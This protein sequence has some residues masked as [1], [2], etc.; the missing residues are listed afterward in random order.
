MKSRQA[1]IWLLILLAGSLLL[2]QAATRHPQIRRQ[3]QKSGQSLLDTI[4]GESRA[5]LGERML[6]KADVYYHSGVG[7]EECDHEHEHH[8]PEEDLHDHEDEH[9]DPD[10]DPHPDD[11]DPE[12][13][14]PHSPAESA[15]SQSGDWW[16]QLNRRLHPRGH[17]H[18]SGEREEKEILPWLWAAIR[19]DPENP[20]PYLDG[21]Y[22][23]GDRLGKPEKALDILN[24]GIERNPEEVELYFA[25]GTTLYHSFD[26]PQQAF[27]VLEQGRQHWRQQLKRW[28]EKEAEGKSHKQEPPNSL[29]YFRILGYMARIAK[30]AGD[31]K[32][33]KN[34]YQEALPVAP[35]DR[36]R[37]NLREQIEELTPES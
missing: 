36:L 9:Q 35:N 19:V 29:L 32:T 20:Q 4:F 7:Y 5:V 28:Q 22:F 17:K 31:I 37:S 27:K 10:D 21:A 11:H 34:L 30:D 1:T 18:L 8:H 23:L 13:Q 3:T 15:K 16:T 14:Q 24:Q 25:K 2:G 6:Y 26:K 12:H 33:A